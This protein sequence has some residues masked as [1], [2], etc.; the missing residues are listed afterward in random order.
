[1]VLA[2]FQPPTRGGSLAFT[3]VPSSHG[4]G[5]ASELTHIRYQLHSGSPVGVAGGRGIPQFPAPALRWSIQ[6]FLIPLAHPAPRLVSPRLPPRGLAPSGFGYPSGRRRV[7][8]TAA[9]RFE[10][11]CRSVPSGN[12]YGILRLQRFPPRGLPQQVV[13]AAFP[14][15][16][17]PVF[18]VF[19]P[20]GERFL[21]PASA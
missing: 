10:V 17:C 7:G 12:A 14:S 16:R 6:G 15:C 13:P 3:L 9:L 19:L 4:L 8:V 20:S 5:P 1:M 18:T 11:P 21:S 2:V